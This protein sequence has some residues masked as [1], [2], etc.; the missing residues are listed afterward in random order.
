M[1][2]GTVSH[3]FAGATRR[4]SGV[5]TR[6]PQTDFPS[7]IG[8][9]AGVCDSKPPGG[10][11]QC[12]VELCLQPQP[13][14]LTTPRYDQQVAKAALHWRLRARMRIAAAV[15]RTCC[16]RWR[17][18]HAAVKRL[19]FPFPFSSMPY[20]C[21]VLAIS[22]GIVDV[23]ITCAAPQS[24]EVQTRSFEGSD[25]REGFR[26]RPWLSSSSPCAISRRR[27]FRR[28]Q[29]RSHSD[30]Q[31][32]RARKVRSCSLLFLLLIADCM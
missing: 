31:R 22:C 12:S 30:R 11:Q 3:R 25:S 13:F 15:C 32:S 26:P 24:I 10:E 2:P 20:T 29:D 8:A 6:R 9:G 23:W 16:I 17:C 4:R 28:N 27:A 18:M 1:C 7:I 21:V 19:P 14:F 5:A